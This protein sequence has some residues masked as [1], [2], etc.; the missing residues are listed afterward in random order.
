[1]PAVTACNHCSPI[2]PGADTVQGGRCRA[3][4]T[5]LNVSQQSSTNIVLKTVD[6]DTVTLNTSRQFEAGFFAYDQHG[7][8]EGKSA[9]ISAGGAAFGTAAKFSLSVE[10]SINKEEARDIHKAVMQV[11]KTIRRLQRGDYEHAVKRFSK[12]SR[13]D[14]ISELQ[15]SSSWS[16]SISLTQ[17]SETFLPESASQEEAVSEAGA[18]AETP[19]TG[20]AG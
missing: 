10:G 8:L 7:T 13:L 15:F 11:G 19:D 6:D 2:S 16:R 14:T 18:A 17:L 20:T 12:L 4:E 1:M 3:N 5:K 9:D